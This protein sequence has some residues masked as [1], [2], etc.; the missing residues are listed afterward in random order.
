MLL[1]V[2]R[3]F[4]QC[5]SLRSRSF[6]RVPLRRDVMPTGLESARGGLLAIDRMI[7][8]LALHV[9]RD[10]HVGAAALAVLGAPQSGRQA[11]SS[12]VLLFA[13]R[14]RYRNPHPLASQ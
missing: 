3:T 11:F 8:A 13:A 9:E 2:L 14:L 5:C 1:V 10:Y 6:W 4:F 7:A 12:E